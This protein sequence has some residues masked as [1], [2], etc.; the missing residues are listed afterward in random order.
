MILKPD[1]QNKINFSAIPQKFSILLA[2]D[3]A[4]DQEFFNA[5][6]SGL[7]IK[8]IDARSLV[9][10]Q[11]V[12]NGVEAMDFL[13]TRNNFRNR[14]TDLPDFI[15]LDLNMPVMDG[16]TV[17]QEMKEYEQLKN[18][19]VYILTTSRDEGHKKK[20][21]ALGCAGFFSKPPKVS[22]LQKV[23]E[24]MLQGHVG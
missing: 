9:A 2:D 3:D 12:Y 14:G 10:V 5:A 21:L 7:N 22:E 20:C 18:I 6:L 4:D 17:L 23:I 13:L 24:T 15:V 1:H 8:G 11:A 16:F 19:P